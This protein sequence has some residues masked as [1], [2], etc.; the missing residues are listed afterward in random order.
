MAAWI[1]FLVKCFFFSSAFQALSKEVIGKNYLNYR[2]KSKL[3][4]YFLRID[5]G[6]ETGKMCSIHAF[7]SDHV[8][9]QDSP[10]DSIIYGPPTSN[11]IEPFWRDLHRRLEKYLRTI[12]RTLLERNE[13]NPHNMNQR[14][15]LAYVCVF[16][17]NLTRVRHV[18]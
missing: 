2:S 3:L 14:Y 8:S 11:K 1:L 10:L 7:P 13:Y 6:T 5:R 12:M 16:I 4:K 15:A 18:C 9:C 17:N